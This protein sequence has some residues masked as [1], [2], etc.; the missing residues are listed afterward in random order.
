[1]PGHA[2]AAACSVARI[3]DVRIGAA[4]NARTATTSSGAISTTAPVFVCTFSRA[5]VSIR[6][7]ITSVSGGT[8]PAGRR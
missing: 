7:P 1:V 6:W 3:C 8:E 5:P 2:S 4:V